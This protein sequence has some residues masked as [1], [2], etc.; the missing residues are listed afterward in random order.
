MIEK[1]IQ[2]IKL[3]IKYGTPTKDQELA[4]GVLDNFTNDVI[5]LNLLHNF[6]SFLPEGLDDWV[7]GMKMIAGRQGVFLICANTGLGNYIYLVNREKAEFL[8]SGTKGIWDKEIIS[9]FGWQE[10]ALGKQLKNPANLPDYL[11]LPEQENHC[12][13]C[14][15]REGENHV[16]GCPVEI[17]PWCSSQLTRCNCRFDITGK[18]TLTSEKDLNTFTEKL[19]AKGRV[20]Y[21]VASQRPSYPALD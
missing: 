18:K 8:G 16:M 10:E 20:P 17:C 2:E 21:D 15:A 13:A 3:L 4:L 1:Q 14:F 6:Y 12:P 9:F 7:S 5:A 11:P 19:N